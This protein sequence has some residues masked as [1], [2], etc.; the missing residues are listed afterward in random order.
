MRAARTSSGSRSWKWAVKPTRSTKRIDTNLRSSTCSGGASIRAVPHIMH[1]RGALRL[2][3]PQLCHRPLRITGWFLFAVGVID[4]FALFFS[5]HMR[6]VEKTWTDTAHIIDTSANVLPILLAIGFGAGHLPCGAVPPPAPAL[7]KGGDN[8]AVFALGHTILVMA[9]HLLS[10]DCDYEDL[11]ADYFA[12]HN[13]AESRKR[14][15]IRQ[16]EALGQR[17]TVEPAA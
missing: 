8:K 15:L 7:R 6:G 2:V 12:R 5:M 4:Q 16:L 11:G 3:S 9:W 13:H 17:V 10:N 1:R 14:Y